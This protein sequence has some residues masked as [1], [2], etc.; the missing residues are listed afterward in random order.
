MLEVAGVCD[1][2]RQSCHAARRDY[3]D[4]PVF[5]SATEM[6]SAVRPDLVV[7]AAPPS[8]HVELAGLAAAHAA[9]VLCEKPAG[10]S[11]VDIASLTE[12]HKDNPQRALVAVYQYRFAWPW[13]VAARYLRAL[14]RGGHGFSISVDIQR[15]RTDSYALS[16]W[17]D[18]PAMGG[19]LA[20]HVVHFLALAR[21]DCGVLHPVRTSRIY[22]GGSERVWASVEAGAGTLETSVSYGAK[23]RLTDIVVSGADSKLRWVGRSLTFERGGYVRRRQ[24]VPALS[25][26][27]YV[28]S[29]YLPLYRDMLANLESSAWRRMRARELLDVGETLASLLNYDGDLSSSPESL[30]AAA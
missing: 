10:L 8:S 1:T 26:R 29:L 25:D 21:V 19:A 24:N 2:D 30:S 27:Q 28:D 22:F 7:I 4:L 6:I 18:D 16:Q 11:S 13:I 12:I 15:P 20:D 5:G 14:I 9:H 3:A 23:R 17:R